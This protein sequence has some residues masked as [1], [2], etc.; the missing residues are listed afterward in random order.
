MKKRTLPR[1]KFIKQT[2]G[3]A[4]LAS[5]APYVLADD[6]SGS[7]R[8]IVGT[9]DYQYEAIHD[10]GEL[11][12][13]HVYGNTHGVAVDLQGHVHIKHT[14]G[15]G[16]TIDDAVVVFDADGKFIRSWGKQYKGGAHG[17]HLNRE[18]GEEFLY[19]CDP[20]RHL[21]AKT[22]LNGKELW[23]MWAP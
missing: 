14:V 2:A 7:R 17:L 3:M 19:L 4:A 9:G 18:G 12:A 22:D 5:V 23:R 21:V 1:R 15:Q 13:G 10:W 11:P 20:K 16:A 8:P 6:K